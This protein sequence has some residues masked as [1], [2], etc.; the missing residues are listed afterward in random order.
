RRDG[1]PLPTLPPRP[2]A[3]RLAA[4]LRAETRNDLEA[5]AIEE[6]PVIAE[7]LERVGAAEGCRLAR[8]SGSGA[9]V[10]G[11]F[12]DSDAADRA[13]QRIATERPDWWVVATQAGGG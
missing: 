5:P 8:M 12:A 2:N 9:T 7:A 11:I 4:F 13:A 6:A 10:F 1:T 3:D